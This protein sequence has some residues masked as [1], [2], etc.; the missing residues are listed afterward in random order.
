MGDMVVANNA[1]WNLY[2]LLADILDIVVSSKIEASEISYSKI[3]I[4]E[5]LAGFSKMRH[6]ALLSLNFSTLY[7]TLGKCNCMVHFAIWSMHFESFRKKMKKHLK[8]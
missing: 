7:T 6:T 8:F 2:I 1:A 3:H 5:F 4:P